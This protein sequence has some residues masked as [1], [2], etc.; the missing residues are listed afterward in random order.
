MFLTILEA[1]IWVSFFSIVLF[2]T[3]YFF[4]LYYYGKRIAGDD[5]SDGENFFHRKINTNDEENSDFFYPCVSMIVP[6]YNEE[7]TVYNKI[8][9]IR[10]LNYPENK[11][12]VIFVDGCSTDNTSKIISKYTRRHNNI[13]LVRQD[14]RKGYNAAVFDGFLNS[15]GDLILI[16]QA[17]AL[18]DQDALKYMVRH[19]VNPKIG[20]VTGRQVVINRNEALAPRLETAY[21]T[22]YDFVRRAETKIDSPFDIKGEICAIRREILKNLLTDN[23]K[24]LGKACIDCCLSC[25]ARL[26]G[27]RTVY[28]PEAKYYECAPGNLKD[29][30]KQ[31]IRRG[32]ILIE[33]LLLYKKML[34]NKMYGLFGLV[35]LP[36]H[37][38]MLVVLPWM[39]ILGSL[40][41]PILFMTHPTRFLVLLITVALALLVKPKLVLSF[42]QSQ[43]ALVLATIRVI[44]GRESQKIERIPSTRL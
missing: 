39:F 4:V 28:E 6:V 14:C 19:F 37:F 26:E 10:E 12:E 5:G 24:L 20:V 9:N 41:F 18:Y 13:R 42:V 38:A 3:L 17:D 7:R 35:I 32:T 2:Y 29:R 43:V 27:F 15:T 40:C 30:M 8:H 31:Q 23:P 22:F 16:T 21:R 25:Q 1:I 36:A 33:S 34:L 11:L 44:L